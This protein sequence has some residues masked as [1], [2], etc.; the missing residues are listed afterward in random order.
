MK[1]IG[2]FWSAFIDGKGKFAEAATFE[3][4]DFK[5]VREKV[6]GGGAAGETSAPMIMEELTASLTLYTYDPDAMRAFGLAVRV[7]Q[8]FQF[9]QELFDTKSQTSSMIAIR[10]NATLDL[11]FPDWDRKKLEGVKLSLFITSYR[12]F[13]NGILEMHIDPEA[14]IIDAGS[15]NLLDGA[16]RA[17]GRR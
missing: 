5:W 17:I 14:G 1:D 12:R 15:G 7:P 2:R 16:M 4:P 11:E 6:N 8:P 13:R 9:R 10:A 3:E